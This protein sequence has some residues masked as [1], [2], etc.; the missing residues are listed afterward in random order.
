MRTNQVALYS[1]YRWSQFSISLIGSIVLSRSL[2]PEGFEFSGVV[3][4]LQSILTVVIEFGYLDYFLVNKSKYN[5]MKGRF[6]S[7]SALWTTIISSVTIISAW[8]FDFVDVGV[9][10]ILFIYMIPFKAIITINLVLNG[11]HNKYARKLLISAILSYFIALIFMD[12]IPVKYLVLVRALLEGLFF[13]FSGFSLLERFESSLLKRHEILEMSNSMSINLSTTILRI[14]DRILFAR[15]ATPTSYA[16]AERLINYS[17]VF[18]LNT[19]Q[20]YTNMVLEKGSRIVSKY[21]L[22]LTFSVVLLLELV[23]LFCDDILFRAFLFL[24]GNKW[25]DSFQVFSIIVHVAPPTTGLVLIG[26]QY[27]LNNKFKRYSKD[28]WLAIIVHL[29]LWLLYFKF[30]E[31]HVFRY[32]IFVLYFT[33]SLI[34]S[35]AY[36]YSLKQI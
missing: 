36:F 23:L 11:G 10:A 18:V 16:Y 12:Y 32:Y 19:V 9:W 3:L 5:F 1:L 26:W 8:L 31:I 2:G 30:L 13:I 35:R 6:Y 28:L 14:Y 29:I 24:H 4:A 27:K 34:F 17:N 15:I 22:L 7:T 20:I 21:G 33:F 25:S